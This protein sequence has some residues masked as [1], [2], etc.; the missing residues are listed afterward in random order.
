[1]EEVKFR[2]E[3]APAP[4]GIAF[5]VASQGGYLASVRTTSTSDPACRVRVEYVAWNLPWKGSF[6]SMSNAAVGKSAQCSK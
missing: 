3:E 6:E 4:G 1:M 2:V 5:F